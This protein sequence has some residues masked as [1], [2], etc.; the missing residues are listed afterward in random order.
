MATP[1]GR[2]AFARRLAAPGHW[3]NNALPQLGGALPASDF[4]ATLTLAEVEGASFECSRLRS[5]IQRYER[6]GATGPAA[7]LSEI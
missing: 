2:E 4:V 5:V 1:E 6:D 3:Q 7:R